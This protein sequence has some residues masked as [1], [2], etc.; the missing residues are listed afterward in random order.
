MKA[1]N[2]IKIAWK[3]LLRNKTRAFLTMLGIIIGVASVIAMLAIGEGSKS[4]IKTQISSMGS[5]MI[6]V[7]PGSDNRGGV[8]QDRSSSQTLTLEDLDILREKSTLLSDISPQVNGNGQAIYAANNWPTSIYGVSPEYLVIRK[9][10]IA[11]GVMFT[12]K[13][14][15]RAAKVA[16]IG[17]TIVENVFPDTDPIG[18]TIRLDKMPLRVVGVLEEKGEN[19]FGQD[20]DDLILSPYTTVQKR[21]LAITH[22][23][24]ITASALSE[25]VS[26]D[27]VEEMT[28]IL[29]DSHELSAN[30]EDDFNVRSQQE[31]LSTMSSTSD[32]LT[33]LLV[34]IASISLLVG[35]IGIMNIMYVSVTERTREIGLRMAVGGRGLDIL[36]QFLIESILISFTGGVI[37]V[38]LGLGSTF[39]V[40]DYMKW[41]TLVTPESIILSFAVCVV[42]GVFFGWYPA[43]KAAKLDPIVALR[44]E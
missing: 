19:S 40:S 9:L 23:Q 27:A 33:V 35:G 24:S 3:A 4:S 44:F 26:E 42:T 12:E 18:K 13:D 36:V 10:E 25:E 38:A 11:D 15:Q 22:L 20:Q 17:Q 41:P 34:A 28:Q 2:L 21:I 31:L 43:R 7:Q 32:M 1:I 14:V 30:E 6:F 29:R 8:R 39:F 5:N 37:G 16:V